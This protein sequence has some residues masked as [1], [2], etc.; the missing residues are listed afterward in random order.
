MSMNSVLYLLFLYK[1]ERKVIFILSGPIAYFEVKPLSCF[2]RPFLTWSFFF[3]FLFFEV[4]VLLS[5]VSAA[6]FKTL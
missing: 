6:W 2:G 1:I 3:L 5:S 4:S